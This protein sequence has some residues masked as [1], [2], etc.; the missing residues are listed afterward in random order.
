MVVLGFLG[1]V[2]CGFGGM[3]EWLRGLSGNEVLLVALLFLVFSIAPIL[4]LMG[5]ILQAI[6][7]TN[8]PQS[9]NSR[10]GIAILV[11][12]LFAVCAILMNIFTKHYC[13]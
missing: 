13:S 12:F 9:S 7:T 10:F 2:G 8:L 1:A 6:L 11:I 3:H 5:Q 4:Y